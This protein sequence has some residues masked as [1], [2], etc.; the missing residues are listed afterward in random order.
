[1]SGEIPVAPAESLGPVAPELHFSYSGPAL[2]LRVEDGTFLFRLVLVKA[3][4]VVFD[5]WLRELRRCRK[6]IILFCRLWAQK[7]RQGP[8]RNH[9]DKP[10]ALSLTRCPRTVDSLCVIG[11]QGVP[12][13]TRPC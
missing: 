1:M 3:G 5:M 11:A 2:E 4:R 12:R 13:V 6:L 9:T 7:G 8:T 10:P